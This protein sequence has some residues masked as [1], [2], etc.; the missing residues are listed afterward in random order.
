MCGQHRALLQPY[1]PE[2]E[3]DQHRPHPPSFD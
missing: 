3:A 1:D 2:R